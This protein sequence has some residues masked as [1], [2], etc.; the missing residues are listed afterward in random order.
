VDRSLRFKPQRARQTSE[1]V[2]RGWPISLSRLDATDRAP[3]GTQTERTGL[4]VLSRR[5]RRV[6]GMG[7]AAKDGDDPP[8]FQSG[9]GGLLRTAFCI[10]NSS[11]LGIRKLELETECS[12]QN[13]ELRRAA[14]ANCGA[15][16]PVIASSTQYSALASHIDP[17]RNIE[18][19]HGMRQRSDRDPIDA[20]F[21]DGANRLQRDAA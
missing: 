16:S 12:I 2:E 15:M 17:H 19:L 10:L 21:G 11:K 1:C 8:Q 14:S 9:P 13:E 6:G 4:V 18:R 7:A 20:G 5:N 3:A